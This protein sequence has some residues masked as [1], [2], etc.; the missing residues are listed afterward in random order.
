VT[1]RP[2]ARAIR[3]LFPAL[4]A[5]FM[6]IAAGDDKPVFEYLDEQTAATITA[7][8]QPLVFARERSDLAANARDYVSLAPIE[9]NRSGERR[10]YWFGYLWSTIDRRTGGETL[11]GEALE[12]VLLGD[13]RP[14]RLQPVS[15]TPRG[16]G[17]AQLPLP[18]PRRGA[19]TLMFEGEPASMSFVGH[20]TELSLV[21][22]RG[23][24]SEDYALWRDERAA[25]TSFATYLGFDGP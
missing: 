20:A 12:F 13:G 21:L 19:V 1:R 25:I 2:R 17:I 4:L 9:I 6:T 3:A 22:I 16:H 10:Y 14:I 7:A 15:G 5:A 18:E 24:L 8:V 23:G 11:Q